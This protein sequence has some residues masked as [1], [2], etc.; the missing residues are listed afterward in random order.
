MLAIG[1]AVLSAL[2]YGASDFCAGIGGRSGPLMPLVLLA[3]IA[4]LSIS[5]VAALLIGGTPTLVDLGWGASGGLVGAFGLLALYWTLAHG[6]MTLAAPLTAFAA[7][8]FPVAVGILVDHNPAGTLFIGGLILGVL[9]IFLLGFTAETAPPGQR[10]PSSPIGT[11]LLILVALLGGLGI[12]T[13]SIALS[14]TGPDAHLWPLVAARLA[15]SLPFLPALPAL[16][17]ERG[18]THRYGFQCG[19]FDGLGN[20]CYIAAVHRDV[21]A[22]IAPIAAF[23][24]ASTVILATLIAKEPIR[25]IQTIGLVGAGIAIGLIAVR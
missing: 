11:P 6:P 14:K 1:L 9:A 7:I 19:L 13:F 2:S 20:L 25:P 16:W 21:L 5:L 23:Y 18:A 24:P 22:V 8:G 4:S 17:R 15:S 12:G 10:Q 3:Q